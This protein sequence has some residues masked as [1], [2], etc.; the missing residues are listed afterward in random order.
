[1]SV[2]TWKDGV[3]VAGHSNVQNRAR[4]RRKKMGRRRTFQVTDP[5]AENDRKLQGKG[6]EWKKEKEEQEEIKRRGKF[7]PQ[8]DWQ[9]HG[10]AQTVDFI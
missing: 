7:Q 2:I 3:G 4:K 1:M 10:S 9:Q 8:Q 6:E 5:K